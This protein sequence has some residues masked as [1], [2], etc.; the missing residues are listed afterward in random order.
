MSLRRADEV[1]LKRVEECSTSS[2]PFLVWSDRVHVIQGLRASLGI[3]PQQ[4]NSYYRSELETRN[5]SGKSLFSTLST[6]ATTVSRPQFWKIGF[7]IRT[8]IRESFPR[9]AAALGSIPP[10]SGEFCAATIRSRKHLESVF[11]WPFADSP[12]VGYVATPFNPSP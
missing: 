6:S 11:P 8:C 1:E 10:C 12:N 4:Q 5:G 9:H 7:M 2:F 3:T